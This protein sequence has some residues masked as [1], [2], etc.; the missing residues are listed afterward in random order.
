MVEETKKS[1][2]SIKQPRATDHSIGLND[3]KQVAQYIADMSLE[4]RNLAKAN[5]LITLQGLLEV[6]FYEAFG[7]AVQNEVPEGEAER[8]RVLTRASEG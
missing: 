5:K 2:Q 8:L 7:A 4:L 3:A 6:V 1:P